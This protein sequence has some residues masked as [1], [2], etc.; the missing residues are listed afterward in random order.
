MPISG[1]QQQRLR[2]ENERLSAQLQSGYDGFNSFKQKKAE[3]M[4]ELNEKME[5][6]TRKVRKSMTQHFLARLL[7]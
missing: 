6:M 7:N 4:Q 5:A 2:E 1:S 3:E